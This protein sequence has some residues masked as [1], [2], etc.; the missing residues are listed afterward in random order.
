MLSLL[1]LGRQLIPLEAFHLLEFLNLPYQADIDG[2]NEAYAS[3]LN[4]SHLL[5]YPGAN[6]TK[7]TTQELRAGVH[8]SDPQTGAISFLKEGLDYQDLTNDDQFIIADGPPD[9][10]EGAFVPAD[11]LYRLC[12]VLFPHPVVDDAGGLTQRTQHTI[13]WV[14]G[15]LTGNIPRSSRAG[16]VGFVGDGRSTKR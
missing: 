4:G 12:R 14:H 15:R 2:L 13:D 6:D 9:R 10:A 8:E 5:V 7:I 11:S 1:Q 3:P 16:E